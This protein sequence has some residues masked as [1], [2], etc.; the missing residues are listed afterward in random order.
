MLFRALETFGFDYMTVIYLYFPEESEMQYHKIYSILRHPAYSGALFLCLGA[1]IIQF[2]LYSISFY[3]ILYIGMYIHIHF[4][5][6]KELIDR[7]GDSY[8]EYR[9]QTP[10]FFVYP[11]RLG[12]FFK[13]LFGLT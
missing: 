13:Y 8:R 7:F 2:T 9:S 3:L 5:E 6:E 1:L 11:K 4:V 12:L 10:A